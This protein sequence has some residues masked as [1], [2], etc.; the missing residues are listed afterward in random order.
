MRSL[1]SFGIALFVVMPSVPASAQPAS[2]ITVDILPASL[3]PAPG[4]AEPLV[5]RMV[6]Q[7]GWHGYWSN[8]GD[9]GLPLEVTWRAP[10]GVFFGPI[11]HPAPTLLELGGIASYVHAGP[12]LLSTSVTLPKAMPVGTKVPIQADVSW[13]ACSDALCVPERK[14]IKF[15]L[16]AGDGTAD[17]TTAD[18]I[19][20]ARHALPRV[21][22]G[23]RYSA[24]NG[25]LTIEIPDG[26]DRLQ[27]DRT[28]FFPANDSTF[29]PNAEQQV[30]RTDGELAIVVDGVKPYDADRLTGVLADG[31]NAYA[32]SA[33][34]GPVEPKAVSISATSASI[35][36]PKRNA[37]ALP[38]VEAVS[39][40]RA[41]DTDAS[42]ITPAG[43]LLTLLAA[44]AGGIILNLM[45]CVFP[46]LS[47]K[48]VALTRVGN[49]DKAPSEAIAYTLGSMIAA[50]T[51]GGL[52]IIL[53]AAGVEAGWAFQLQDPRVVVVLLALSMA[54]ALNFAGLFELPTAITSHHQGRGAF[55]TGALAALVATP[56]SGPFMG[57]ALGA[58]MTMPPLHALVIFAGLGFGVALPF[59]L[60]GLVP[61]VRQRIPRPGPWMQTL[62]HILAVPMLATTVALAWLLGRQAGV[63]GMSIGLAAIA[64][65]GALLW[66]AG[67]RQRRGVSD[68]PS[69]LIIMVSIGIAI[70]AIEPSPP[71]QAASLQTVDATDLPV[72][73]PFS[74]ARLEQLRR[75][76]T[77]VF[78][79]FTADWCLSC[80]V[81]DKFAID[82]ARTRAA[83][84]DRGVVTLV[85][86]WTRNDP[87]ITRFLARHG[88]NSI[89][90]Y[91]FYHPGASG[92][93]L[94]Q[95]LSPSTLPDLTQTNA[96]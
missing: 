66:W 85:G 59:L 79:D 53:R 84:R 54:I 65:T 47:L 46:I 1:L 62:R 81:N 49:T 11:L 15:V 43:L 40:P 29:A 28:R 41:V 69:L 13:L 6:P 50:I 10:V 12:A 86:D 89:P 30:S 8:P 14:T 2:H 71:G 55:A 23:G 83:F 80:K 75:A 9:S 56:C 63:Q 96:A 4:Q 51:L 61:A 34:R 88:R 5:I 19:R 78:V 27:A 7:S 87:A 68:T 35:D 72:R 37:R 82:T 31:R 24:T 52:L 3:R 33:V 58:A 92:R 73:E 44:I 32:I 93:T 38:A 45:P 77:P 20:Q 70:I 21:I 74:E 76:G 95:I 64:M 22:N 39:P 18:I 90:F 25:K 26:T 91:L 36:A 17:P 60:I 94:P 16:T 57:V 42:A 67:M 48:A